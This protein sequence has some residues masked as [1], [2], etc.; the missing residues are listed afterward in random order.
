MAA[1]L[2]LSGERADQIETKEVHKD[3]DTAETWTETDRR[4]VLLVHRDGVG[5][6]LGSAEPDRLVL[7]IP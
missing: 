4:S 2:L 5:P 7:N 6:E 1:D 3:T